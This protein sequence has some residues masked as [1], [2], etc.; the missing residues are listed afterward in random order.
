MP[1]LYYNVIHCFVMKV[2]TPLKEI[3]GVLKEKRGEPEK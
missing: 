2:K 3:K 1:T